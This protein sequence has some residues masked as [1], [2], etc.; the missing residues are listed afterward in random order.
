[1]E[2]MSVFLS[3]FFFILKG[4][5]VVPK[6]SLSYLGKIVSVLFLGSIDSFGHQIDGNRYFG[7]QMQVF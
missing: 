1:M 6:L 3:F 5:C 2:K 4:K 7:L